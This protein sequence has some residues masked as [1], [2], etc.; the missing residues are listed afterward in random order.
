[1]DDEQITGGAPDPAAEYPDADTGPVESTAEKAV[2][3]SAARA[4]RLRRRIAIGVG[5]V[6]G[7]LLLVV[8]FDLGTASPRF[9]TSCHEMDARGH[10]WSQSSHAAVTCVKCHQAPHPWYALPQRLAGRTQLLARDVT[11]HVAGDYEDPVD[12]RVPGTQPV[13]DEICL[14]CHDVN[15]KATSGFR[16]LIDHP[17]H[18]KRNGSCVSCH[19]RTAHPVETRG[20]AI[21]FMAQCFTCHGNGPEAKASGECG[22]CHPADY[23]LFP[24]SHTAAT[25]KKKHGTVAIEDPKQCE[26]CHTKEFCTGCHGVQMPHPKDWTRGKD[27]HAS[28]AQLNRAVCERCHGTNPD[29]CTMCHHKSYDPAKG[30]WV[31]Q[32][33]I[34]VRDKG[35]LHC[36]DCHSPLFCVRC[37]VN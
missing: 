16:I 13:K 21:T 22:L 5:V 23:K 35:A 29:S 15:R 2:D 27:G 28:V 20:K 26:M 33:F 1:M 31:K 4:A 17:A 12:S 34:A 10:S 19:V 3:P 30:P 37:H 14:Q 18:A 24:E 8:A 32:H 11:A 7:V 6:L 25:W 36:L 9:C